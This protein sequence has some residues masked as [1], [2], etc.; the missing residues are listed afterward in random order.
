M[1]VGEV[2]QSR[3]PTGWPKQSGLRAAEP[4]SPKRDPGPD[5]FSG[6][7]TPQEAL[8]YIEGLYKTGRMAELAKLLRLS[9]VFREAW[10]LVQ[11]SSRAAPETSSGVQVP[12]PQAEIRKSDKFPAAGA[13]SGS[14]AI[15]AAR[16]CPLVA[17]RLQIY[18][19]QDLYF[20][21]AK[22]SRPPFSVRV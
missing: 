18:Q 4:G 8:A 20:A 10:L 2:I 5:D 17:A 7:K 22:P 3:D 19:Q 16:P 14:L 9:R 1:G 21:Q 12:A 6:V 15:N 13:G 11:Q